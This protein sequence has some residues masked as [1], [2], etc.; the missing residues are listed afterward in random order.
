MNYNERAMKAF[1]EYIE[2]L[3][4]QVNDDN[5]E[6]FSQKFIQEYNRNL[7]LKRAGQIELTDEERAY[8]LYQEALET[9]D[10]SKARKLLKQAIKLKPDYLDAK[11][12]LVS[13]LE[14][15]LKRIRELE[16]LEKS[17]KEKLTEAGY[18]TQENISH[19]YGILETRPYIRLLETI[20]IQYQEI[21]AHRK[22]ID[23][24]ENIIYLNENDNTGSRYAL[25]GLYALLEDKEKMEQIVQKYP[26]DSVPVHL[27]QFVLAYKLLEFSKARRHLR[28]IQAKVPKFKDFINGKLQEEDLVSDAPQ[29]YYSPY[30]IEEI[31]MYMSDNKILFINEPLL[32]FIHKTLK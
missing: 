10:Y 22:A 21:G 16:K 30:T 20:A 3:G 26:E 31:L 24:Y 2:S 8:D 1:Q 14:D 7:T 11:V 9:S 4:D 27:F 29:G 17:E 13:Y 32:A 5:I 25:M 6:E 12:E 28:A 23:I 19:F 15:D 18:F